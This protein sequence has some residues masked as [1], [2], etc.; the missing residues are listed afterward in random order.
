MMSDESTLCV[1]TCLQVD[2]LREEVTIAKGLVLTF[3]AIQLAGVQQCGGDRSRAGRDTGGLTRRR[4]R[5]LC[6]GDDCGLSRGR[7]GVRGGEG[8][9]G[10]SGWE[11]GGY[12]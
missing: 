8:R 9:R 12:R 4:R 1:S 11:S 7:R 6:S 2:I 10:S 3:T 5:W